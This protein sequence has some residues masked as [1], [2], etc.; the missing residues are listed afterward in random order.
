MRFCSR[1][2]RN[3]LRLRGFSAAAMKSDPMRSGKNPGRE[4]FG[5]RSD[6]QTAAAADDQR[7]KGRSNWLFPFPR[8]NG[9]TWPGPWKA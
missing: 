4:F 3:P 5:G 2:P 9:I 1:K 7:L 6:V 8:P